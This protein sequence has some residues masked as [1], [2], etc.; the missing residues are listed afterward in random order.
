ME[1]SNYENVPDKPRYID[2]QCVEPGTKTADGKQVL[3][4]WSSTLT[5]GT[6]SYPAIKTLANGM[7]VIDH[8]FPGAQVN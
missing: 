1:P 5:R 3:N 8:D 6:V 2:F 7:L 4:R